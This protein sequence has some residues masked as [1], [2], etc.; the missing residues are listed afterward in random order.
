MEIYGV[1]LAFISATFDD[2]TKWFQGIEMREDPSVPGRWTPDR[3]NGVMPGLSQRFSK[4]LPGSFALVDPITQSVNRCFQTLPAMSRFSSAKESVMTTK[5]TMS[6]EGCGW[7]DQEFDSICTS[8]ST[9]P[10]GGCRYRIHL[11]FPDDPG[12]GVFGQ[13]VSNQ[14]GYWCHPTSGSGGECN[15]DTGGCDQFP[16]NRWHHFPTCGQPQGCGQTATWGC[17]SPFVNVDGICQRSIEYQNACS[18]GYN[19]FVC[20]CNPPP[21]CLADGNACFSNGEC[22]S[23]WCNGNTG[24]CQTCPGQLFNGLCTETPII[25]DTLGNG[26]NLTNPEGGVIF[27]LTADGTAERVSWTAAGGDDAWLALDR[28]GNGT[29]DSGAELFGSR[30]PQPDPP[31]GQSKNGFL[32]L[33]EFDKPENGGNGDGKIDSQDAIFWS[34]RL[35]Q[36][37]NHNGISEPDELH[38]LPALGVAAIDLDYRE[39]RRRD[40][41][42]NLFKYRAKVYSANGAQLGRWAYDVFLV[43]ENL[44]NQSVLISQMPIFTFSSPKCDQ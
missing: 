34:L 29:I 44:N 17:V 37:V 25:I 12:G 16:T 14:L 7:L 27:D 40:R 33:A 18:A 20:E 24:Q 30:S 35:W 26:F 15:L 5:A 11:T 21:P 9:P 39:S 42:G 23:E 1:S 38:T 28:N 31:A 22:C 3:P 36:D 43:I 13:V 8:C 41:H 6:P 10:T 32:A 2:G 19:S 4:W